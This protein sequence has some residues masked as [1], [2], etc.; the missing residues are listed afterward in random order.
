MSVF[1]ALDIDVVASVARHQIA[2]HVVEFH[3]LN[4]AGGTSNDIVARW[5]G[6]HFHCAGSG[7]GC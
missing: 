3:A 5:D 4:V 6:T 7:V 2:A 1:Y